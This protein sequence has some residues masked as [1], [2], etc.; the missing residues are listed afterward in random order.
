M[1]PL[2]EAT[3]KLEKLKESHTVFLEDGTV[4]GFD[5]LDLDIPA[6]K[7]TAGSVHVDIRLHNPQ[8]LKIH[9]CLEG[10]ECEDSEVEEVVL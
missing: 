10:L 3:F 6:H 2:C 8:S 4:M 9:G 5:V 7:S 1:M